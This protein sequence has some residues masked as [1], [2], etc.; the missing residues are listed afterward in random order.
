MEI[1][2]L[3]IRDPATFIPVIAI[4]PSL[5]NE[6]ERY[7]WARAGFGGY[8]GDEDVPAHTYVILLRLSDMRAEYVSVNWN[9]RTML[10][11][12]RYITEH[13]DE[14]EGG[15]VIDVEYILGETGKPKE[16]ERLGG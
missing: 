10:H 16:S 15:Q 12:H 4:K 5:L 2:T 13:W 14:I 8:R 3:E 1:K 11:A 9:N 7:L 6:A